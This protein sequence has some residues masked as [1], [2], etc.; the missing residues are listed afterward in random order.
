MD[1]FLFIR[2]WT[3][4]ITSLCLLLCACGPRAGGYPYHELDIPEQ[5][6]FNGFAF[7]KKERS[8]DAQREFEQALHLQ[9]DC[10]AA[11][12]GMGL[13]YGSKRD[14]KRAFDFMSQAAKYAENN[15]DRALA[16]VGM[17][18]LY[19]M[20]RSKG[21]LAKVERLFNQSLS[22]SDEIPEA[23]LELG[24]AYKQAYRFRDAEKAFIKV[25]DLN[26]TLLGEAREEIEVLKKIETAR[27]ESA[28]GKEVVL[29]RR[30][31]RAETAALLVGEFPLHHISARSAR[32]KS[33]KPPIPPPDVSNHRMK[34]EILR[35]MRMNLEG[36]GVLPD[37]S[38]G[39]DQYVTRGGFAE[40]MA[41]ILVKGAEK[42]E[43][44]GRYDRVLSPFKDVR[45][46][47]PHFKS[48]MI[49]YDWAGIMGGWEGYFHPM[50]TLSGV[51]ALLIIRDAV[52]KLKLLGKL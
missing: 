8:A 35:V 24:L 32:E 20:E 41:D 9:P 28:F 26:K 50:E 29:S 13:V 18:S 43:L 38:F 51:D 4:L 33:N 12:R 44:K 16:D 5:R 17:A 2:E 21:W 23:Y 47:S 40:V 22:W 46:S 19:R 30:I 48:I 39:V 14:F 1:R 11:Y 36:L 45:S 25:V 37:G 27:P 49:C 3:V 10:S 15:P 42:P 52:T 7:L 6:V 34:K 31:N